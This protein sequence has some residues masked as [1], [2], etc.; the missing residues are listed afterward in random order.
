MINVHPSLLPKYRGA[1]PVHRAVI[2]GETETGVTIMRVAPKLDAG[3]MFATAA[4]ADRPGRDQRGGRDAT[5]SRI[6]AR[7]LV[8]VVDAHGRRHGARRRRRT[9][10]WPPTRAS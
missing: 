5:S 8:E 9:T 6:G 4:R 1:A 3:A 10:P 2:A 7:L